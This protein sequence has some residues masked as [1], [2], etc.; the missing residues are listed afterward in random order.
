[1]SGL[2]S[3]CEGHLRTPLRSLQVNRASSLI[4]SGNS[5]FLSNCDRDLGFPIKLQQ[6]SQAFSL[7]EAWNSNFFSSCKRCASPPV[8]LRRGMGLFLNVQQGS[9]TSLHDVRGNSGFHLCHCRGI[10]S[11]LELRV[12]VS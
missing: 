8:E 11:N 3:H 6:G 9:Q 2:L 4:E 12:R 7:V 5:G 10:R 1:M